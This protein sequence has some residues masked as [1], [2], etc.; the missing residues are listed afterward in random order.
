MNIKTAVVNPVYYLNC[1][2]LSGIDKLQNKP[3]RKLFE[4]LL[5]TVSNACLNFCSKNRFRLSFGIY[6]I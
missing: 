2:F 1:Y 6:K 5:I 3:I 4:H